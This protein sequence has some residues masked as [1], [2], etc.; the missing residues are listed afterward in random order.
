MEVVEALSLGEG[1]CVSEVVQTD[2][3]GAAWGVV[4]GQVI[5]HNL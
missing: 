5:P 1:V 3:T 2:G 4:G